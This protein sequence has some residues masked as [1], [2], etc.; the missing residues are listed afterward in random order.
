MGK[1]IEFFHEYYIASLHEKVKQF[2]AENSADVVDC[3][4]HILQ[5]DKPKNCQY[6]CKL[7]WRSTQNIEG[8]LSELLHDQCQEYKELLADYEESGWEIFNARKAELLDRV[9]D[10][11]YKHFTGKSNGGFLVGPDGI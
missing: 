9:W 10:T 11:I 8:T 6:A 2:I 5:A 7:V 4:F 3:T 1:Q